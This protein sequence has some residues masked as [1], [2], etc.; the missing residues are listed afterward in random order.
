MLPNCLRHP[1]HG[2]TAAI[3]ILCAQS[4]GAA[5]N[6]LEFRCYFD[7]GSAAVTPR[8]H[9]MMQEAAEYIRA[10]RS[11][12]MT[13][14]HRPRRAPYPLRIEIIGHADDPGDSQEQF[15]LGLLRAQSLAQELRSFVIPPEIITT[16]SVGNT[17]PENPTA[18]LSPENR[19]AHLSL[20]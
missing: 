3:V 2:L 6:I 5:A 9:K 17:A 14:L 1:L 20:R 7:S 18:T 11:G 15:R 19:F 8:C 4:T 10:V 13:S 12:D 16:T